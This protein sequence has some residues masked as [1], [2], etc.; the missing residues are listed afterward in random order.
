MTKVTQI[1]LWQVI[2]ISA[3]CYLPRGNV[4]PSCHPERSPPEIPPSLCSVLLRSSTT[5]RFAQN[6]T[7]GRSRTRRAMR[8]IGIYEGKNDIPSCHP[9]R[10]PPEIPPSLCSVLLRSS[11]TLRFAQN[12]TGGRSRTRRAMRSIGIY[13]GKNAV[14]TRDPARLCLALLRSSTSQPPCGFAPLRMTRAGFRFAEE[15][16]FN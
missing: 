9:E 12:D 6:D 5:L 11:T 2:S 7:G 4:S 8:S 1:H 3:F 13:E 14:L 10:S 16:V 15:Y